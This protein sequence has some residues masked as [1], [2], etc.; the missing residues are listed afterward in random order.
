MKLSNIL[1]PADAEKRLTKGTKVYADTDGDVTELWL[2]AK[3]TRRRV[4]P[5]GSYIGTVASWWRDSNTRALTL[6]GFADGTLVPV[7]AVAV[8][9]T[10]LAPIPADEVNRLTQLIQRDRITAHRLLAVLGMG[11]RMSA[12]QQ[13]QLSVINDRLKQRRNDI[14]AAKWM[15]APKEAWD[16]AASWL[17]G[18]L[19]IAALPLAITIPLAIGAVVGVVGLAVW[20][21][22]REPESVADLSA[23]LDLYNQLRALLPSNR[24][25][26]FDKLITEVSAAAKDQAR[27]SFGES[28]GNVAIGLVVIVAAF[29]FGPKLLKK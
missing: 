13:Q 27:P 8:E 3:G 25:G 17:L 9:D 11:V 14:I 10:G 15:A 20:L 6:V 12:Q 23:S 21:F 16:K 7:T 29:V 19:G 1:S 26:D 28:I 2:D 22:R 24:Q 18:S 4:V 5:D